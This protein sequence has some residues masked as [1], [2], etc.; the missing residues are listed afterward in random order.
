MK[1]AEHG[2]DNQALELAQEK[3]KDILKEYERGNTDLLQLVFRLKEMNVNTYPF[4]VCANEVAIELSDDDII[5]LEDLLTRFLNGD[6]T[7]IDSYNAFTAFYLVAYRYFRYEKIDNYRSVLNKYED[8]FL[9]SAD[10]FALIY[11]IKARFSRVTGDI[12]RALEYDKK[13]ISILKRKGIHNTQVDITYAGTVLKALQD[14]DPSISSEDITDA[15]SKVE[16]AIQIN[17]NVSRYYGLL[18]KFK[19]YGLLSQEENVSPAQYIPILNEAKTLLNR[20]IEIEDP[21]MDSY[22][23]TVT[24][25]KE[26]I[27]E[28]DSILRQLR[29]NNYSAEL[30]QQKIAQVEKETKETQ[31]RY[32]EILAVFVAIIAV[33][34]SLVQGISSDFT[35]NQLIAMIITFNAGLLAVYA[36]FLSLLRKMEVKYTIVIVFCLLIQI[37]VFAIANDWINIEMLMNLVFCKGA[38]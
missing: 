9:K 16:R 14:N 30:L 22:V 25:Y 24:T 28:A 35:Y 12:K 10:D 3:I 27:R 26:L 31:N 38:A 19:M 4:S 20:A 8:I 21:D 34:M 23:N 5:S 36:T 29:F 33:I 17:P 7:L 37:V 2:N 15:I 18:A 6:R 32:L 11:Q 1:N 13:A